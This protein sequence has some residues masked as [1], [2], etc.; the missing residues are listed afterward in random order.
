MHPFSREQIYCLACSS[1]VSFNFHI[2]QVLV[3]L[4]YLC[5][6]TLLVFVPIRQSV[7]ILRVEKRISEKCHWKQSCQQCL[8]KNASGVIVIVTL[9]LAKNFVWIAVAGFFPVLKV[10]VFDAVDDPDEVAPVLKSQ[11]EDGSN[12]L[13]KKSVSEQGLIGVVS[14]EA[15]IFSSH[16]LISPSSL[17]MYWHTQYY[18]PL[19]NVKYSYAEDLCLDAMLSVHHFYR[20]SKKL[21]CF[22]KFHFCKYVKT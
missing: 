11:D 3:S 10:L 2:R 17:I 20:K 6:E 4:C 13:S 7:L 9:S 5:L 21:F 22:K 12:V 19:I 14:T 16:I 1:A 8:F 18:K 15:L